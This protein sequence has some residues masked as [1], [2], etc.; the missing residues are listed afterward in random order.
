MGS[1][2]RAL[3]S[4]SFPS[5]IIQNFFEKCIERKLLLYFRYTFL[6]FPLTQH[7]RVLITR[8]L[9]SKMQQLWASLHCVCVF[10]MVNLMINSNAFWFNTEDTKK[11][12]MSFQELGGLIMPPLFFSF[13]KNLFFNWSIIALQNFVV[14]RQTSTW[15]SHSYTYIPS[16]LNLPPISLPLPPL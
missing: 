12:L 4:Q 9:I 1:N 15:I 6:T 3:V 2:Q 14:F 11:P 10:T 5:S 7:P 16:L 13:Y 8:K